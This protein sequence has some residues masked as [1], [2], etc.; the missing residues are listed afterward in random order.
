MLL[1]VAAFTIKD[2]VIKISNIWKAGDI[3]KEY[4]IRQVDYL[5][6]SHLYGL[7]VPHPLPSGLSR[8]PQVVAALSFSLYGNMCSF[9]TFE[10]TLPRDLSKHRK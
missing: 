1:Y 6:K 10:D 5:I 7:R 2:G 3:E 4:A 9:G 8:N